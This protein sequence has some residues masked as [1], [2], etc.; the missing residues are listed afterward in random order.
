M[1]G[2]KIGGYVLIFIF[3]LILFV[4]RLIGR[5]IDVKG[6]MLDALVIG[7][8]IALTMVLQRDLGIGSDSDLEGWA[9]VGASLLIFSVTGGATALFVFIISASAESVTREV[10]PGKLHSSI[11]VRRGDTH[12]QLVG[13]AILRGIAVGGVLLGVGVLSLTVMPKLALEIS[14]TLGVEQSLRPVASSVAF[15]VSASYIKLLLILL[16]IGTMIYRIWPKP[17]FMVIAVTLSGG[18]LQVAPFGLEASWLAVGV[19]LLVAFII[20]VTY[21]RYDFLTTLIALFVAGLAWQMSE[22]FLIAES[23]GWIDT[24]LA[25]FVVLTLAIF[26]VVGVISR[27]TGGDANQYVPQYIQEM[28]GQERIKREL[29]I[30]YQVQASFL[31]RYMPD[32]EGLDLAGMCLPASEIG[33]D[34]FDFIRL[35]DGRLAFVVGDVSGKG[36]QAAFYMTLVKGVIQTLSTTGASPKTVMHRLNEVFRRNAPPGTFISAIYGIVDPATGD[37]TFARAGHNPAILK[38]AA[39]DSPEFL[40]PTGMAIG[41]TDGTV[42]E[43]SIEEVSIKL[44][45]GD[46]MVFYTDGFSE[47]MNS[48]REL[49]GD[50]RLLEKVGHV[51]NRSASGI[52]RSL[53]E[54]VHHFIEG[55][56]RSDDMTMVVVKRAM[57]P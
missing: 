4:R 55:T 31:P 34:Y 8:L 52:L 36:I 7:V 42:F 18:L 28:A 27:R 10:L 2:V 29:E 49:F 50:D 26:G 41:F 48:K 25:S 12:N 51:G 56:G 38:R 39:S 1:R 47:A 30:A 17:W 16:G 24:L 13:W 22:G 44:L 23:P 33:G 40:L 46:I 6:S 57:D 14:E 9:R 21:V 54:S 11:L 19:S 15:G 20:A 35:P 53:T 5:L 45:P 37:F 32:V 3:L 43:T